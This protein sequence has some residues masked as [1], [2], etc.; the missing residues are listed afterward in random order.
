MKNERMNV[1]G[2]RG[3]T[4]VISTVI[5]KDLSLLRRS[6]SFRPRSELSGGRTRVGVYHRLPYMCGLWSIDRVWAD[7]GGGLTEK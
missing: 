3:S 4:K 1:R 2:G 6:K 7:E 5:D